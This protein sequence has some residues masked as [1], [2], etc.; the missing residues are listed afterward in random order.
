MPTK[1]V[2]VIGDDGPLRTR[3]LHA[4]AIGGGTVVPR[5]ADCRAEDLL[6]LRPM[7]QGDLRV[8]FTPYEHDEFALLA[9]GADRLVAHVGARTRAFLAQA[10]AA[11]Q[12]LMEAG[13]GQFWVADFDDSF[14]YHLDTPCAPIA[15]QARAGAV[16]SIAKEYSR[17]K[18]AVNSMLVQPVQDDSNAAMFREAAAGL[19]SFAMRYKPTPADDVAAMLAGFVAQDRLTFSGSMVGTGTGISQAHLTL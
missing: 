6:A 13:G 16:R 2:I 18:I 14:A 10:Q 8:V 9:E 5:D 4:F 12:L 19:K 7:V 3:I 17:M 15:A 1:T 11:L